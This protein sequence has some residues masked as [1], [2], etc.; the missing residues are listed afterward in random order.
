MGADTFARH[1]AT[2]VPLPLK[3]DSKGKPTLSSTELYPL[4]HVKVLWRGNPISCM[5]SF[6]TLKCTICMKERRI[7]LDRHNRS[8]NELINSRTEIY[9]ACRH[10]PNFHRYCVPATASTDDRLISERINP[11]SDSPIYTHNSSIDEVCTGYPNTNS[12]KTVDV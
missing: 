6:G 10:N 5:E 7:I 1:F 2:H 12:F 4:L 3:Q 9:G 11:N 8:P